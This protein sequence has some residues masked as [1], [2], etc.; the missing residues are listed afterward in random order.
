MRDLTRQARTRLPVLDLA[1]SLVR[2]LPD[3]DWPGEV[4]A[5]HAFVRDK[6]RYIKDVNGIETIA[7]PEKTLEYGQGDCD[8]QSVLLA[9]LLESIG[10]PARFVAIGSHSPFSYNHVFTET[11]IGPRW[12]PVET[13]EPVDMGWRPERILISMVQDI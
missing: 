1:R 2:H 7:T 11:K 12:V 9:S 8:D 3:K 4:A 13:T 5:L 10:H 6:I